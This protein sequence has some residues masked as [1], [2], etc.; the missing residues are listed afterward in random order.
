MRTELSGQFHLGKFAYLKE[1]EIRLIE[2]FVKNVGN[3]KQLQSELGVVND[4]R[5]LLQKNLKITRE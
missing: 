5:V 3:M 2:L 1:D 4:C